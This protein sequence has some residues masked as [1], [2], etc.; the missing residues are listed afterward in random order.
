MRKASWQVMGIL[1]AT[2]DSF[3]DGGVYGTDLAKT[4]DRAS[5]MVTD[6]ATILDIGGESTRPGAEKISCDEELSRVIPVVEAI[7]SRFD[8]TISVDTTK[9]EVAKLGMGS[10]AH[11]INDISAGR[12]DNNM[13]QVVSETDAT[14]ILMHSRQTPKTMQENPHYSSTTHDVISELLKSVQYFINASV[15]KDKIVLDPG[16]GFAKSVSDNLMLLQSCNEFLE[17]GYPLLIGTSRKSFIG[18]I[19]GKDVS[20]RVA[21]SLATISETYRQG[22]SIFRV[23]DVAETVDLLKMIDAIQK[24]K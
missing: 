5:K 18:E 19:T 12:F 22:A 20:E 1:N 13:A 9:S 24:G 6:G 15:V 10:G 2:P 17:T 3:F 14:I 8:I 11:W 7:A 21:G 16:I 23:H 4:I